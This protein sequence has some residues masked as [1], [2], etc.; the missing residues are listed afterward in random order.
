MRK[1][2]TIKKGMLIEGKDKGASD[3]ERRDPL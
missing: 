1:K 2:G 3:G